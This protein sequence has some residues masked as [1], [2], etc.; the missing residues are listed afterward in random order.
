LKDIENGIYI[1]ITAIDRSNSKDL[2]GCKSPHRYTFQDLFPLHLV[3]LEGIRV[4]RPHKV[5]KILAREYKEKSMTD[6]HFKP[7]ILQFG[8]ELYQSCQYKKEWKCILS[9]F[10]FLGNL[11]SVNEDIRATKALRTAR[12]KFRRVLED[13]PDESDK[14]LN[15]SWDVAL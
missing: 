7:Y 5:I 2:M 8:N 14:D 15:D 6:S 1:E 3:E 12:P 10:V 11:C 4:L 9:S 13:K